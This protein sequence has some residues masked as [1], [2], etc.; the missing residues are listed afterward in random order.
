MLFHMNYGMHSNANKMQDLCVRIASD[1]KLKIFKERI[2]PNKFK[3]TNIEAQA[4]YARYDKLLSICSK[5]KINYILTGHHEDDQI[6]T[7]YMHKEIHKSSWISQI[8]I[9]SK[10]S[11][12]KDINLSIDVIRPMLS[13]SRKK[14]IN[15]AKNNK[16]KF[17]NDPTNNDFRFLRNKIRHEIKEKK[18]DENFRFSILKT[19]YN[20][21]IKIDKISSDIDKKILILLFFLFIK[22]LL[23]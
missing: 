11:L 17:Y 6:E 15:Y 21:K 3:N 9:R 2:N 8:G 18:Q 1:N 5:N 14:I 4:R 12:Y 20:N 16:L 23:F 7:I 19:K 10:R 13:I 22:I